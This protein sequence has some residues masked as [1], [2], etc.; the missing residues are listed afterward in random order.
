M[1]EFAGWLV[2]GVKLDGKQLAYTSTES[3]ATIR[4]V[5]PLS[6]WLKTC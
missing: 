1:T 5:Y 2:W 4:L 3:I 6:A